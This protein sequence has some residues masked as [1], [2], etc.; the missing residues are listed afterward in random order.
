MTKLRATLSRLITPFHRDQR[1]AELAAE[2]ESHLQF[3]IDDN[4]RAGMSPEEA[5]R[6]AL[7]QLGGLDQTKESV[8]ARRS[9]PWLDSLTQDVRFA[10]RMLRKNPGFTVVAVLTLA[11]GIGANTAIFTVVNGVMLR[12][13]PYP[14]PSQIVAMQLR[15]QSG[16]TMDA[17]TVPQFRFFRDHSGAFQAVAGVRPSGE[18]PLKNGNTVEWVSTL[19]VTDGFFRVV[20][21]TPAIGREFTRDETVPNGP[22]VIILTDNVWRSVFGADRGV[23][24]RQIEMNDRSYTVIGVMPPSFQFLE[25]PAG[26]LTPLSLG[27]TLSDR[28]MNTEVLARMKDGESLS[29]AQASMAVTY[30]QFR[31][32][33]ADDN[34]DVGVQLL[35]YQDYLVDEIAPSLLMLFGAVGLLLLVACAN[36][37]SL[38]LARANAREAEISIR[39][40]LGAS[41]GRLFQQLLTESL[42]LAA[43]GAVVGLLAAKASLKAITASIP[44]ILP[45]NVSFGLDGNVLAFTCAAGIAAS[46][47]FGLASFREA[48]KLDLNS[49]LKRSSKGS[50]GFARHRAGRLLIVSEVALA[51]TLLIG[52][53]LLI[54]SLYRLRSQKLGFDPQNV[55]TMTTPFRTSKGMPRTALWSSQQQILE[56][57]QAIPGVVSAAAINVPP[58]M[59]GSNMPA[60]RDAHPEDS[61][62]GMEIRAISDDY[63]KTMDIPL[64]KG[65]AFSSLDNETSPPVVMIDETVALRWWNGANPIGDRVVIGMMDGKAFIPAPQYYEIV[66]IVGDVKGKTLAS[67]APP[68]VYL[69]LSQEMADGNPPPGW[70]IRTQNDANIASALRAAV[71]EVNPTQRVLLLMPL[72]H[73]ID[74]QSAGQNFNAKLLG[75]FAA[76]GLVLTA[77]GIYGVISFHVSQRTQEIGVRLALGASRRNVVQ[78]VLK[79]GII[80]ASVGIG[81]GIIAALML[82]RFLSS[83]L[84]Q[85]HPVD[86]PTYA[87]VTVCLICVAVLASYIPAR[88]AMRIDPVAAM[89]SE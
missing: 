5:R 78:L 62:G 1:D 7:I 48:R 66:G 24:G 36:V 27:T 45:T 12:P 14:E 20:S 34:G 30:E 10:L 58:L 51:T 73:T 65:R 61:I 88:R 64:L 23:V 60:Q 19:Q 85:I 50:S 80:L 52:A 72:R 16:G 9:L 68:M 79:Q 70:V 26:I 25:G 55:I 81:I 76:L 31:K 15:T 18:I 75:L 43:S 67:R 77:V 4:L 21:M 69:P 6:Q 71:T 41:R 42:L 39:L 8:R 53:G 54:E 84:F 46:I 22:S 38:L 44:F 47:I 86:F 56:R 13:L 59:G 57:I 32:Q 29:Q 3:H 11:L 82:T 63:L 40:A 37:A 17:L 89:R 28:G 83:L 2:L 87:L 74:I 49:S 35:R 33:R